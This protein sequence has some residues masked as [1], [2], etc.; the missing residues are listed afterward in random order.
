MAGVGLAGAFAYTSGKFRRLTSDRFEIEEPP[1]PGTPEFS[2]LIEAV[3]GAP[4][5]NGNRINI[6]R[7][8]CRTFPAMLDAIRAAEDTV[9]FSS[10]I[11]WPSD[12]TTEFNDAFVDRARA[13][14][15]VRV[16]LDGYGSAK[17]DR[18]GVERLE[19][20][21]VRVAFFRPPRWYTLS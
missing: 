7:N 5:R 21:G 1:A 17:F 3:T 8:G 6:L 14:V 12:V 2:R 11:Y 16:V 19:R 20:A 10:Y 13:G 4:L 9:D 15:A 18:P